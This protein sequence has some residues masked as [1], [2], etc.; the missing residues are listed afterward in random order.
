MDQL[1]LIIKITNSGWRN[2]TPEVEKAIKKESK[3]LIQLGKNFSGKAKW[4]IIKCR[5][6]PTCKK[7]KT[8]NMTV[9]ANIYITKNWNSLKTVATFGMPMERKTT[10][11]IPVSAKTIYTLIIRTLDQLIQ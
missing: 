5:E 1:K 9:S 11:T 6:F 4:R 8:G 3:L 10:A 2:G 7:F